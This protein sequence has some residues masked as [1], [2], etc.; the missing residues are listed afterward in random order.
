V[1]DVSPRRQKSVA[2]SLTTS[3]AYWLWEPELIVTLLV[4]PRLSRLP[5]ASVTRI[6]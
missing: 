1:P 6:V 2:P 5:N 3:S 4:V